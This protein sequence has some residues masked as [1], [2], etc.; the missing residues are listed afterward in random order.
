MAFISFLGRL[1]FVSIFVL[2][3]YQEFNEFGGSMFSQTGFQV[4]HV[5]IKHLILGAITMKAVRSLLF[6]FGSSS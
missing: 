2:S 5:E 3:T 1:M 4:P 6:I